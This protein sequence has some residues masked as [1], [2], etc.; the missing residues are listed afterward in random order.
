MSGILKAE[1]T[2]TSGTRS[3]EPPS[4]QVSAESSGPTPFCSSSPKNPLSDD[5]TTSSG[6]EQARLR[7]AVKQAAK[8]AGGR[9]QGAKTTTAKSVLDL[10]V[11]CPRCNSEEIYATGGKDVVP[12]RNDGPYCI[13]GRKFARYRVVRYKCAKCKQVIHRRMFRDEITD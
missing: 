4:P 5:L 1:K 13:L 9:P 6:E 2:I 12:P 11:G 3:L 10:P 7:E 8:K